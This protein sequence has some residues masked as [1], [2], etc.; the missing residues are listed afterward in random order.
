MS[1]IEE[2]IKEVKDK[3][4]KLI[5]IAN[6]KIHYE[7][8]DGYRYSR[9]ISSKI[10][11]NHKFDS[12]NEY[13]VYNANL[14]LD[15]K[16]TVVYLSKN[17][18]KE[19]SIF[20]CGDCGREF[21][22]SIGALLNYKYKCCPICVR[23]KQGTKLTEYEDIK[24]EVESFGYELLEK[25]FVGVHKAMTIRDKEGYK[26]KVTICT[27]RDNGGIGKFAKYNPYALE[28]IRL[29]CKKKGYN[30][31]IPNQKYLGWGH[32][33]K[34]IC[35]CGNVFESRVDNL[36]EDQKYRCNSCTNA[37]SKIEQTVKI[38]LD[39]LDITYEQQKTFDDCY[40]KSKLPFDFYIKEKECCIEVQGEQHFRPVKFGGMSLKKAKKNFEK[41]K[42]RDKIKKDFCNRNN[43]KL[44]ELSYEEIRNA[45]ENILK[46]IF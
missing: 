23:N 17:Q 27:L 10:S 3:N 31:V 11:T 45:D 40:Y 34:I 22:S 36:I 32:K 28:N 20:L 15:G 33:I 35:E 6:N 39:E 12:K 41:Q 21:E 24:K 26:G 13:R 46:D 8:L 7:D 5:K 38:W 18:N 4:Y 30:C 2:K 19:K 37:T 43:I 44:I 16:S 9:S 42:K 29:F 1:K 14:A 25:S